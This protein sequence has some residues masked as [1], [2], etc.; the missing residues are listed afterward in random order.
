M[1]SLL[2]PPPNQ[3]RLTSD[4]LANLK[5]IVKTLQTTDVYSGGIIETSKAEEHKKKTMRKWTVKLTKTRHA[6]LTGH[7]VNKY[8][9]YDS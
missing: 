4:N 6:L 2:I 3:L 5:K 7:I 9:L 8:K 1:F